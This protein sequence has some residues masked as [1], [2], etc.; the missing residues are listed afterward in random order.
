M[1]R[2]GLTSFLILVVFN[3]YAQE[4]HFINSKLLDKETRQPIPFAS[5]SISSTT[6]GTAADSKGEFLLKVDQK[7]KNEKLKISCIGYLTRHLP[8]DSLLNAPLKTVELTPD[9]NLLDEVVINQAPITSVEIIQEALKSISDNYITTPYNMEFYSKIIALEFSSNKT[10]ELETILSGYSDGY[11]TMNPKQFEILHKRTSGEDFLKARDY[12]YWPTFELHNV[13][14]LS[15]PFRQGIFNVKNLSKFTTKYVG[16]SLFDTD[17]VYHIEYYLPKPTKETTGYGIVP[18]TYKGTIY[19]TT[20]TNAIVKHEIETDQFTYR[21]IYKKLED[22]YFPYY[23]SGERSPTGISMFGKVYNTLTLRS[24]ETVNVK[25]IR[26]PSN[27]FQH[28]EGV[29][30]DEVFWNTNYPKE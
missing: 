25:T 24:I 8:I 29:N 3:L 21:I 9:V 13:D 1:N 6:I 4:Y 10:F 16:V 2:L 15:A 12:P 20:H 7:Y 5:V 23:V 28:H 19:I 17:T 18:K 26:L 22:K 30:Y 11:S 14:Q 27:E